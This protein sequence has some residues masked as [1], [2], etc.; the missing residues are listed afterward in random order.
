MKPQKILWM[1]ALLLCMAFPATSEAQQKK[2]P[3]LIRDTDI[4]ES[5]EAGTGKAVAR[6]PNPALAKK[7]ISIGNQY[8]KKKNYSAAISRYLEAI[9]YQQDSV[10]AREA[11]SKA[12]EKNRE[13]TN[14]IQVL[15]YLIEKT[16]ASPKNKA[17]RLKRAQL[18]KELM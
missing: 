13:F 14:A 6:E 4:E 1:L 16:P 7:N 8:F 15:T 11:L 5:P 12:Y 10:P 17:F 2:K 9:E 3:V 18:E